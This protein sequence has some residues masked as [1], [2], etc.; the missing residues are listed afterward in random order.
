[1]FFAGELNPVAPKAQRKVPV[2]EGLD[3]DAWINEP[4]PEPEDE[5]EEDSD[6]DSSD[7]VAAVFVK[8]ELNFGTAGGKDSKKRSREPTEEETRKYREARIQQQASDP[9]YL[10][11][12]TT[13]CTPVHHHNSVKDVDSI[14]V[15]K[16]SS[17]SV[18]QLLIPG[19]A[20]A[21]QFLDAAASNG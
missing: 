11:G 18:P 9:N 20:S 5:D 10:K 17:G 3:L 12:T 4:P 7:D 1:M 6:E 19:L 2:P 15:R 13:T 8:S 21:D 16:L 14:P